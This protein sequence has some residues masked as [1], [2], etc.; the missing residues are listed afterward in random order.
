[1]EVRRLGD[2]A[3]D[4]AA[5]AAEQRLRVDLADHRAGARGGGRARNLSTRSGIRWI[6]GLAQM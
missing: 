6:A 1:V 3:A 2:L 4:V 5:D